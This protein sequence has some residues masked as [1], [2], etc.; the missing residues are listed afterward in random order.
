MRDARSIYLG[1]GN[2]SRKAVA[3]NG[4]DVVVLMR[5]QQYTILEEQRAR[6][7]L[8]KISQVSEHLCGI[9]QHEWVSSAASMVSK[10]D[11]IYCFV[12]DEFH[13]HA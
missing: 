11:A 2:A 6:S 4:H 13:H 10:S 12:F 3:I 1:W 8:T 9:R 7:F 5:G